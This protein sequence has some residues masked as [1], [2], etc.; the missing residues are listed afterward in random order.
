[1]SKRH[2]E[3]RALDMLQLVSSNLNSSDDLQRRYRIAVAFA[4]MDYVQSHESSALYG[5]DAAS[6]NFVIPASVSAAL[7][8][9]IG[10]C[11]NQVA[12][13]EAILRKLKVPVRHVQ[14]WYT[15]AHGER[16]SH[17]LAEVEW[18]RRWHLFDVTWGAYFPSSKSTE[19]SPDPLPLMGVLERRK[20]AR[21]IYNPN[22]PAIRAQ[23]EAGY[24]PFAYLNGRDLGITI[25]DVGQVLVKPA[26]HRGDA[27]VEGFQN[28]PNFVGFN[29]PHARNG[30]TTFLFLGLRGRFD[31]SIKV[32]SYIGCRESQLMVGKATAAV[33]T[34]V[35]RFHRVTNP[36]RLSVIGSDVVCYL[37][38][39]SV[40]FTP[41]QGGSAPSIGI[42]QYGITQTFT[43][44]TQPKQ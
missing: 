22:D 26:E 32:T 1:M 14:L 36:L 42:K 28:I 29:R 38:M 35:I 44:L 2:P 17:I 19:L 12:A 41:S 31:V 11:G 8:R 37:T 24:D 13:Y 9:G 21:P 3:A 25:D 30:G 20:M 15:G 33:K 27:L 4:A 6:S 39:K 7:S 23:F 5:F 43:H 40:E 18:D 10:I 34:G 16:E